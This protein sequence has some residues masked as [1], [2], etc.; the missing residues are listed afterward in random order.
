MSPTV[1]T[2]PDEA[3]TGLVGDMCAFSPRPYAPIYGPSVSPVDTG[4]THG[5]LGPY[6]PI[7][8]LVDTILTRTS[9]PQTATRRHIM[10]IYHTQSTFAAAVDSACVRKFGAP[11]L[12]LVGDWP[13]ADLFESGSTVA[14]AV[15]WIAEESGLA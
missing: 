11:A 7:L 13:E 5:T 12:S 1:H 15:A 10:S 14:E 9:Q 4:A 3:F 8:G 6:A 2:V